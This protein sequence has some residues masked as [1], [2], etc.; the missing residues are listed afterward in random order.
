MRLDRQVIEIDIEGRR[1]ARHPEDLVKV[2]PV[3][4]LPILSELRRFF[5][6]SDVKFFPG[7]RAVF[8]E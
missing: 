8:R 1:I 5:K 7:A 4:A 2:M 6:G 3:G